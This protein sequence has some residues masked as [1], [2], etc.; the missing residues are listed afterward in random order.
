MD[1]KYLLEHPFKAYSE[2]IWQNLGPQT[3]GWIIGTSITAAIS[4]IFKL[5]D[6]H[7]S[8]YDRDRAR[9][10]CKNQYPNDKKQYKRCYITQLYGG[11]TKA[12]NEIK[13]KLRKCDRKLTEKGRKGC[14]RRYQTQLTKLDNALKMIQR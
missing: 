13:E 7:V 12:R 4:L 5:L 6:K 2:G 14:K 8:K 3:K 10:L 1:D 11:I 9:K